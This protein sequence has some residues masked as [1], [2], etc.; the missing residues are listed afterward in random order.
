[1]TYRS[2]ALSVEYRELSS[3]DRMSGASGVKSSIAEGPNQREVNHIYIYKRC[4]L[5][6]N[7]RNTN[8]V[9]P[10][11]PSLFIS[12]LVIFYPMPKAKAA[13]VDKVAQSQG[14]EDRI[15]QACRYVHKQKNVNLVEA[16]TKFDVPYYTLRRRYLKLNCPP[17]QAPKKN[18]ILTKIQE[19]ILVLWLRLWG[20]QGTPVS[21]QGVRLKVE[22]LTGK[23][24]NQRWVDRF[25]VRHPEL[26]YSKSAPLDTKRAQ[27]F[28]RTAIDQHFK[29]F[30]ETLVAIGSVKP[31]NLYNMDEK[32]AQMGG[33]RKS[34]GIKYF[35]S[36]TDRARYKKRSEDLEL[37][38]IIE[39]VSADGVAL[40]PGFVFNGT[41]YDMEW[42]AAAKDRP[43]VS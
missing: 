12:S 42:F 14:V 2:C 25:R 3:T 13:R 37:V 5:C 23:L 11:T 19:K 20:A 10:E 1:M 30:A 33:G 40:T 4:A 43:H 34:S 17:S 9:T 35:F 22:R 24:P 39:C 36:R 27:C 7:V 41:T 38:T 15:K 28:N 18:R 6:C 8:T 29:D 31:Q 16:A 26:A 32:G 21:R